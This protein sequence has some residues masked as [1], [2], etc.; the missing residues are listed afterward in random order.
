MSPRHA[1]HPNEPEPHEVMRLVEEV[2]DR[3]W[4]I[5][6]GAIKPTNMDATRIQLADALLLLMGAE[7]YLTWDP[8]QPVK[9]EDP[10]IFRDPQGR[11][12]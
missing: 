5:R 6:L 8:A 7:G 1:R 3:A 10:R 9:P 11:D 2:A 4:A 12:A